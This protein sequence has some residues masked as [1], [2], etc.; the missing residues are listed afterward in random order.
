[1]YICGEHNFC[2]DKKLQE[3]EREKERVLEQSRVS[4]RN[5]YY[6]IFS[7]NLDC[8][9]IST[10]LAT[11]DDKWKLYYG[12]QYSGTD[13]ELNR[14]Q[15]WISNYKLIQSHNMANHSF[16]LELNH[17]ADLVRFTV[18]TQWTYCYTMHVD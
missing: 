13:E 18:Y 8:V 14:K 12:K 2:V 16:K 3:K 1:M 7:D 17:F 5:E 15:I 9:G 6:N 10:A 4:K 11:S